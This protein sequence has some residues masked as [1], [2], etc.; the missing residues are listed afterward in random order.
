[1]NRAGEGELPVD[2]TSPSLKM[3]GEEVTPVVHL[4]RAEISRLTAYRL[5]LD[6]TTNWAV[7]TTAALVAFALGNT[8]MPHYFFGVV[9][10]FQ[11]L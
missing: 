3:T 5:R 4:Y 10:L 11:V 7:T 1:M 2:A 8:S 6:N 9:L